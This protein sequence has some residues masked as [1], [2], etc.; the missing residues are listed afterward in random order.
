MT[1]ILLTEANDG[2]CLFPFLFETGKQQH[3]LHGNNSPKHPPP[4]TA[5][6]AAPAQLQFT[7]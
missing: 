5:L 6:K 4:H 3:Q 2:I 1:V 7:V